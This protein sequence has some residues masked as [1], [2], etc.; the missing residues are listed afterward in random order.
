MGRNIV[1][2]ATHARMA[3]DPR[4]GYSWTERWGAT[5]EEWTVEGHTFE[6][7][8]GDYDCSSST[9]TAWCKALQGTKYAHMLD[10]ATYTG[11]MREVFLASGLFEWK[12]MSFTAAPG[13]LYLNEANHVAM[14]QNQVPDSLS[15]FSSSETGGVYGERG[16]Q[17]GWESH[18]CGYYDY[19]WDGIL[20]Y[21]GKADSDMTGWKE[22]SKGWWWDNGDG[23]WPAS[24]WK[25][26][27]G[28]WYYFDKN[29]YMVTGWLDWEGERYYL[30]PKTKATGN[31]YGYMVTGAH[32]I[33]GK[34][35]W[36]DGNGAMFRDGFRKGAS[37]KYWYA[38]AK[39]G[40]RISGAI[41]T[42]GSGG[43]KLP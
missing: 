29:G 6:I 39:D 3:T 11:N 13:D 5:P 18:I 7:N 10:G 23:T 36:F 35:Y 41:K 38:Y 31:N 9:I 26:V 16:D 42:N 22:N 32:E 19:P 25:K 21:N 12:P 15:E 24:D 20:H 17:T 40:H 30:K 43:I 1:A 27:D 37:G 34:R 33:E 4:F 8:V 2:A 14:C 28:K